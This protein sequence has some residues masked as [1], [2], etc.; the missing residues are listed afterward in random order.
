MWNPYLIKKKQ[1]I[2]ALENFKLKRRATSPG[3]KH[4]DHPER[5]KPLKL[6]TLAYG[7]TRGEMEETFKILHNLHDHN[8]SSLLKLH[9]SFYVRET[10]GHRLKLCQSFYV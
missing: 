5:L 7:R 4:L 6:P 10:R 8:C 9:S 2:D 1:Q 3:I